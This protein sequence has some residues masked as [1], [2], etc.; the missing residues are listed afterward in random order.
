[1]YEQELRNNAYEVPAVI[2]LAEMDLETGTAEALQQ[3]E[4]RITELLRLL[5]DEPA[6]RVTRGVV[7]FARG[8]TEAAKREYEAV[9]QLEPDHVTALINL[10][11]IY[12]GEGNSRA[13]RAL[14]KRASAIG[15]STVNEAL[16]AFDFYERH[17]MLSEA[18]LAWEQF[19]GA[20]PR[21]PE[22]AA[23]TRWVEAISGNVMAARR[24]TPSRES[25]RSLA[26]VEV[27]TGVY[28]DLAD[29]YYPRAASGVKVLANSGMA[30]Q[31][32]RGRLLRALERFDAQQPDNPWTFCFAGALLLADGKDQAARQS[33]GLCDALCREDS[34]RQMVM[35]LEGQLPESE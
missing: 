13:A 22:A 5:P 29:G 28:A 26:L 35:D 9:L 11:G 17:G 6:V 1:M 25:D 14:M 30:G 15:F 18:L 7:Q 32:M 27:A 21:T 10:A 20:S 23:Y 4:N 12:Q 19:L 34:C 24:A 3:A 16:G 33:M 31:G 8:R 2:A